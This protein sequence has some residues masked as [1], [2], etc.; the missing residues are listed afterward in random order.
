[1]CK[2]MFARLT[3]PIEKAL[4]IANVTMPEIQHVEVVG[5]AWRV[6]KVQQILSE[7]IEKAAEKKLPLGQHLNGE[8]AAAL[9]A[10]LVAANSSSSFRVK[11]IFFT[12]I[13]MH[14]YSVQVVSLKG[15]WAKNL[16]KLYPIGTALGGKKKLTFNLE[17][18]FEILV[19]EDGILVSR[20]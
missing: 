15:E 9:G 16:T 2:D 4:S 19:F 18:D 17:E 13:T 7:A 3:D 11:K 6:P 8:E 10:A 12:D 5:G 14:E 1:M 20:Y